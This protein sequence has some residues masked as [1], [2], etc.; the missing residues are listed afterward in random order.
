MPLAPPAPWPLLVVTSDFRRVDEVRRATTAW[1]VPVALRTASN[2]IATLRHTLS[3]PTRLVIVDWAVDESNG[4]A[5]VRLL[6]RVCPALP[7]LAF[8]GQGAGGPADPVLARPWDDLTTV[9][10]GW[11]MLALERE[12]ARSGA[13]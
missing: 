3:R 6:G 1:P 13:S 12:S 7:V 10:D 11:L 5:L 9:L 2:A 8:D 4:Q